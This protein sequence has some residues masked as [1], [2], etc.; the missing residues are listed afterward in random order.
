MP[1]SNEK[2][3]PKVFYR[4]LH[5]FPFLS[6][7]TFGIDSSILDSEALTEK[8]RIVQ[9]DFYRILGNYYLLFIKEKTIRYGWFKW[10]HVS[11]NWNESNTNVSTLIRNQWLELFTNGTHDL[12]HQLPNTENVYWTFVSLL[13]KQFEFSIFSNCSTERKTIGNEHVTTWLCARDGE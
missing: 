12:T 5:H 10:K 8:F 3:V 9:I 2:Q 4:I 6:K 1:E 11:W 13:V 7:D